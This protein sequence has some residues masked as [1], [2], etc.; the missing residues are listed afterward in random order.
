MVFA[1]NC[2]QFTTHSRAF[3]WLWGK[4]YTEKT[5]FP[6]PFKLNGIWSWWQVSFRFS[7]PNKIPFMFRI[8]RKTVT[9]IISHLI[10]KEIVYEFSQCVS[11]STFNSM[12]FFLVQNAHIFF[13]LFYIR[14]FISVYMFRFPLSYYLPC[15]YCGFSNIMKKGKLKK[16]TISNYQ[17]P[18]IPSKN[19]KSQL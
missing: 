6:F 17:N 15:R 14:S 3:I 12:N 2:A 7:E 16:K 18:G 9:A 11:N 4:F 13:P 19:N 5:I 10:W 8:E 1:G